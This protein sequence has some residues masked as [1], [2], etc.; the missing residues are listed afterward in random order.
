LR[1]KALSKADT[2]FPGTDPTKKAGQ[3]LGAQIPWSEEVYARDRT[4]LDPSAERSS[5]SIA[6]RNKKLLLE[7]LR[8]LPH[9]QGQAIQPAYGGGGKKRH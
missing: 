3:D 6:P 9:I 1:F 2:E 5:K 4:R 8:V 7:P